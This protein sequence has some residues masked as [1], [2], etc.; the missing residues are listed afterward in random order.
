MAIVL[1][2]MANGF[3]ALAEF[4]IIASRRS[5]LRERIK[6]KKLGAESA[7]KLYDNPENFLA[8]VQVGITLFGALLGVF[9][10]ATMVDQLTARLAASPVEFVTRWSIPLAVGLVVLGITILSVVLGELMPKYIALSNP[11]RYAGIVAGPVSGFIK[12]TSVFSRFLSWLA[13]SVIG[14]FGISRDHARE[15]ISEDEIN[16]MIRDGAEKG[17]F[18]ETEQQLIRSAFTFSD[19]TVRRAMKPRTVVIALQKNTP[20]AE[21]MKIISSEAYSRYPVYEKTIDYVVGILNVKDLISAQIKQEQMDLRSLMRSP[22]FVPDSM[23]LATLLVQFRRGKNHM[24]IV[25]DEFGGTAGIITLEDVLE[26]LVGEIQDEHDTENPPLVRH[27]QTVAFADGTV[28]PGEINS[29]MDSHLPEDD[30]DT[31]AGLFI[32]AIGRMP[33]KSESVKIADML[34]TVLVKDKNRILR[35]K[36]EKVSE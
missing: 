34:L 22:L 6:Q 21:V 31:V 36:L 5:K 28:W 18:D 24:A 2:V 1:L 13:R 3:F 33:E 7:Y 16:Q 4:S 19:S 15:H 10:G 9:S 35:L 30:A 32:D 8:T 25:L 20:L 26:E 29:L 11:E 23:P 27:S 17:I 14:F 12:L